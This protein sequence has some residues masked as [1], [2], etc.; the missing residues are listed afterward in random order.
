[1]FL[2]S[3]GCAGSGLALGYNFVRELPDG[4]YLDSL[5]FLSLDSNALSRVPGALART[6]APTC[7][8]PTDNKEL[9]LEDADLE[10]FAALEPGAW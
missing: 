4:P 10:V 7:L 1:M 9:E 2:F 6:S 8:D 5:Q 3:Q